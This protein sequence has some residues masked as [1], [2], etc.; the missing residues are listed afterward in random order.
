MLAD[1]AANA[2]GRVHVGQLKPY[3]D[4]YAGAGRRG[5]VKRCFGSD[6]EGILG[7]CENGTYG[8]SRRFKDPQII[9]T[10]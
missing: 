7:I 8:L 1:A 5:L 4:F 3:E 9:I 10:R 6:L 2:A